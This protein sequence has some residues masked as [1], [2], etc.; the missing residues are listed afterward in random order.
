MQ[1]FY[2]M[3]HEGSKDFMRL[4]IQTESMRNIYLRPG[5]QKLLLWKRVNGCIKR[6]TSQDCILKE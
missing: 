1:F 3:S 2:E 6:K 5:V 4:P